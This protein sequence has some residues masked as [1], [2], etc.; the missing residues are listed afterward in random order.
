MGERDALSKITRYDIPA[1]VVIMPG[2]E[3]TFFLTLRTQVIAGSYLT[4][5]RLVK[6]HYTW[7]GQ[8]AFPIIVVH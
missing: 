1:G 6:E 3:I 7:F 4:D 5:W 8:P 2:E